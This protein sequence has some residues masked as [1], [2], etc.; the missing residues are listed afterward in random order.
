MVTAYKDRHAK[1]IRLPMRCV[2]GERSRRIHR[3]TTSELPADI[4]GP[5]FALDESSMAGQLMIGDHTLLSVIT[6]SKRSA[7]WRKITGGAI[8]LRM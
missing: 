4:A 3:G 2:G 7:F 8:A 5:I 1:V 6:Q